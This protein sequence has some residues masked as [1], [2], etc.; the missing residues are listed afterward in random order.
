MRLSGG[1]IIKCQ[2][3]ASVYRFSEV[4]HSGS[5]KERLG[6]ICKHEGRK[7]K[8][9]LVL[10]YRLLCITRSKVR[11]KKRKTESAR[12]VN[13][14]E[15][16][17]AYWIFYYRT[18]PTSPELMWKLLLTHREVLVDGQIITHMIISWKPVR[19]YSW[20]RRARAFCW[21]DQNEHSKHDD[22]GGYRRHNQLL[23]YRASRETGNISNSLTF[24]IVVSAI[25]I[26]ARRQYNAHLPRLH[27]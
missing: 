6:Y 11:P 19:R 25:T 14:H 7:P 23:G 4:V 3:S 5:D 22:E 21:D 13:G 24:V 8:N 27:S 17:A 16:F 15:C 9:Q 20:H 26:S 10:T 18:Y 12:N 2:Q 1:C